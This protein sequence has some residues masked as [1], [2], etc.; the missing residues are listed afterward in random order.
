M[1]PPRALLAL[2][3]A[4]TALIAAPA[5]RGTALYVNRTVVVEPGLVRL[6]DLVQPTGETPAAAEAALASSVAT[7]SGA[8]LV[9]PARAY[10]VLLEQAFGPDCILV[11]SRTLVVPRGLLAADGVRLF[12]ELAD[13]LRQ[14]GVLGE[15]RCELEIVQM[16]DGGLPAGSSAVF[17]ITRSVKVAGAR[18]IT[19][20]VS[21]WAAQPPVGSVT[22]RVRLSLAAAEGVRASDRVQ[23]LFRKGPVTVEMPGKALASA[24]PG[25]SVSVYVP[26]SLK[27]FSGRVIGKKAVEVE[28]P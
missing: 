27:S 16:L 25:E 10:A 4:L 2:V 12:D 23:V 8:L 13:F 22:L 1:R 5:S 26:D 28:L 3:L 15:E 21:P 14:Q 24:G 9:L 19:C 17:R 18:E 20:S 11:G 7:V 6:R